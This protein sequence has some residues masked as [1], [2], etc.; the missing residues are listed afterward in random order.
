MNNIPVCT[1]HEER[2]VAYG[3]CRTCYET[4]RRKNFKLATNCRHTDKNAF[5][6]GMCHACYKKKR[7][8]RP[9]KCEHHKTKFEHQDGYCSDCYDPEE[10]KEDESEESVHSSSEEEEP[11]IKRQRV[12]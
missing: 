1:H 7:E 11:Q 3:L 2:K 9:W 8:G 6:A 10:A 5:R 12:E 4:E